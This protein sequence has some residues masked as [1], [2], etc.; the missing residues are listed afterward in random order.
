MDAIA[1]HPGL[2]IRSVPSRS[3]Q[4]GLCE[5]VVD[6]LAVIERHA[7]DEVFL[8]TVGTGQ[9]EVDIRELT[10]TVVL[11]VPPDAGDSIQ[12]MKAGIL[13]IADIYVVTKSENPAAVRMETEI[14]SIIGSSRRGNGDWNPTVIMTK[15]DGT[16]IDA[17][18]AAIDRH[19]VYVLSH[20]SLEE[21]KEQRRRFHLKS[22]MSRAVD[23]ILRSGSSF[24]SCN[25]NDAFA[26]LAAR[27]SKIGT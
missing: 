3:A 21:I 13:E 6:L 4:N 16:G 1:T 22:L 25:L 7:F 20:S 12:A 11:L 10:D 27:L 26:S 15:A 17:L 18:S 24:S 19:R 8:E 23:Q 14:K 9:A 2:F 5:N